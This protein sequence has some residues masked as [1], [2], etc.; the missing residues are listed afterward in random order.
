VC[1]G[2]LNLGKKYGEKRL[3]RICGK[4]NEFGTHSL[5]RIENML[6]LSVEEEQH[7]QLEL[8]SPVLHHQNIRGSG[9]YH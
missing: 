7:P 3:E 4:A 2:I 6:K 5:K 9:Y 8:A 1:L